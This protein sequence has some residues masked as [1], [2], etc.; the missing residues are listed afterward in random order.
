MQENTGSAQKVLEEFLSK[1]KLVDEQYYVPESL[2]TNTSKRC[3]NR[4]VLGV[5]TYLQVVEA[6]I[7]L[8]TG[9]LRATNIAISWVEK[10]ALPEDIRQVW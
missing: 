2:E 4:F 3:D 10:A 5:D 6:H 8:L 9:I 7:T 1:W